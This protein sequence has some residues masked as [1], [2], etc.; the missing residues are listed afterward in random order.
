MSLLAE[1]QVYRQ[2]AVWRC[3]EQSNAITGFLHND[4]VTTERNKRRNG[5]QGAALLGYLHILLNRSPPTGLDCD[6]S[7]LQT[8]LFS[9]DKGLA[10]PQSAVRLELIARNKDAFGSGL[11][12]DDH[13]DRASG[14]AVTGHR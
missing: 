9:S 14:A 12:N 13:A 8:S 6:T 4:T 10:V 7:C 11:G 1:W 3:N 2:A 5:I